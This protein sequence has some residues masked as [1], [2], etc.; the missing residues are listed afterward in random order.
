[1]PLVYVF[2]ASKMEA[3]PVLATAG[4]RSHKS[5]VRTL[6]PSEP[7]PT[8]KLRRAGSKRRGLSS[9]VFMLE[10]GRCP[11]LAASG[12]RYATLTGEYGHEYTNV[13]LRPF[14]GTPS[15]DGPGFR[16]PLPRIGSTHHAVWLMRWR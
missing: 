11:V 4:V 10:S 16:I 15:L 7:L 2:A 13:V 5:G 3:Q 14:G 1:M 6:T 8:L 9:I 12:A